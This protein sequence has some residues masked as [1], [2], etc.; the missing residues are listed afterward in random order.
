ML[1][2]RLAL[3]PWKIAP[4]SQVF[5][6][7][8]VG[9]LLIMSAF[10]YWMQEGLKPVL[11]RLKHEQVVTAYLQPDL[12]AE[13]EKEIIEAVQKTLGENSRVELQLIS[14]QKFISQ[15]KGQYPDLGKELE[16]MGSEMI[17]VVPRYLSL[18]GWLPETVLETLKATPGVSSAET[19]Q[20][21]YQQIYGAFSILRWVAKLMV[22]G[23]C[24][25]LFTGLIHL[26]RMN[27]YIHREVV[28]ILKFWGGTATTQRLPSL[29]SGL[30]IGVVGGGLAAIAW[31]TGGVALIRQI[32]ELSPFLAEMP[33]AYFQ[34]SL[35]L[36]FTGALIGLFS[37][38]MGSS[39]ALA[40]QEGRG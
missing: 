34:L 40:E 25:A 5:S 4:L 6:A 36:F 23:L 10:L 21:R 16:E 39:G 35:V 15:I 37:G 32:R 13:R 20:G 22:V 17:Q 28:G 8:A 14:P 11:N 1:L 33:Q 29:I 31:V 12:Q 38:I 2:L 30:S 27:S 3:R 9:F 19:S 26:A 7:L 18:S 24:L